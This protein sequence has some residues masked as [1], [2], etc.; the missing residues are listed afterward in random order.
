MHDKE[1][2]SFHG[3]TYV[4]ADLHNSALLV[5]IQ[6]KYPKVCRLS[7]ETDEDYYG[8][9]QSVQNST[10]PV[11]ELEKLAVYHVLTSNGPDLDFQKIGRFL[12]K[13]RQACKGDILK[14]YEKGTLVK[15]LESL[16]LFGKKSDAMRGP[17]D[18][19]F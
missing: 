14:A 2:I 5:Q 16:G 8:S 7:L 19:Y 1:Q 4:R 9:W 13:V 11:L 18:R 3:H 12:P 10:K 6:K 15:A 17:A